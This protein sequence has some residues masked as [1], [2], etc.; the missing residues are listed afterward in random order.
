MSKRILVINF[1][2]AFVPPQSGGELRYFNM[3]L[4]LSE[5]YDI[6]LLSPTYRN[7]K[8]EVITHSQ[9]FREYRV[10][11]EE[12]ND[13]LHMKIDQE[14]ICS[15]ISALVCFETAGYGGKYHEIY[16]KLY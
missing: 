12:I 9:S 1:F 10:P 11:K 2:P 6:T 15:E 5:Y 7:H 16:H 13:L 4:H 8:Y 14:K 3:Y